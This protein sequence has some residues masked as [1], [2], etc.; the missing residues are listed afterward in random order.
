MIN[1]LDRPTIILKDLEINIEPTN[2]DEKMEEH[3]KDIGRYPYIVIGNLNITVDDFISFKLLNNQFLPKIELQFRDSSFKMIDPLF[4]V[5]NSKLS[6]FIRSNSESLMPVR[7]DF[8][9]TQFN[10]IKNKSGDAQELIFGLTGILDVDYLYNTSFASY[11]DSS[12]NTIRNIALDAQLGFASN[13]DT[14]EDS[15]VWINPADTYM[16]FIQQIT[17]FSY[18]TSSSFMYSYVD[19]YYNLNYVDIET[20]LNEDVTEQQGVYNDPSMFKGDE[21]QVTDLILT[22]HPDKINTST[23]IDKYNLINSSTKVNLEIGYKTYLNYYDKNGNTFYKIVMDTITTAG[24]DGNNLIMKGGIGEVSAL[25]NS[26]FDGVYIG[27]IDT[28]NTHQFYAIAGEQ[29]SKNLEYLQKVKL[30]ISL[31]SNNF[32]LYRF[33]K[34]HVDF[35]KMKEVEETNGADVI[36]FTPDNIDTIGNDGTDKDEAKLNQRLSGDWLIT[37]INYTFNKVSDFTQ[38][39]TLVRRELSFNDNDFDEDK[40]Y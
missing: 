27:K 6:L 29:N 23:Y 37:S 22:D 18:S 13:I 39:V 24:N 31:K 28:D 2:E 32:N 14:T 25:Q 19:F 12:F 4:P 9:I 16:E 40:A 34:I 15:M 1:V 3:S 38:D 11:D 8:K 26:S 17:K 10:P 20:A 7:M 36:D 21:E 33:Q 5:D 35:Y 30:K